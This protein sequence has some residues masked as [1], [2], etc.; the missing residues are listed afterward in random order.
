[1][2]S[3][4]EEMAALRE[5]HLADAERMLAL[6][7]EVLVEAA[8]LARRVEILLEGARIATSD[9]ARATETKK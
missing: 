3:D 7:T 1:M 8:A 6:A 2:A 4:Q 5:R 9:A